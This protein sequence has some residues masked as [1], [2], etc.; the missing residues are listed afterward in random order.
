MYR[1]LVLASAFADWLTKAASILA[2]YAAHHAQTTDE[3]AYAVRVAAAKSRLAAHR[4]ALDRA[5]AAY[6]AAAEKHDADREA[7]DNAHPLVA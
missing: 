6:L 7:A 5:R 4:D 1:A 2:T 3:K